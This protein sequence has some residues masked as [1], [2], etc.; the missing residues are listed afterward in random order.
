[1]GL[2]KFS[3]A[4]RAAGICQ[5]CLQR[6]SPVQTPAALGNKRLESYT[7]FKRYGPAP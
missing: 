1:M 2:S 3:E 7:R 4:H 6:F 5:N